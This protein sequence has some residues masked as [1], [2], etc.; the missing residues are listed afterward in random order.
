MST[1]KNKAIL[2]QFLEAWNPRE[3]GDWKVCTEDCIFHG[4]AEEMSVGRMQQVSNM[5]FSAFPDLRGTIEDLVAEG[6]RVVSREAWRGTHEGEFMGIAP[7]GKQMNMK[8]VSIVRILDGRIAEC[9]T[10]F[11]RLALME[12]L[13]AAQPMG[14]GGG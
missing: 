10:F 11:D 3:G 13:G 1:E 5:Y 2:R 7:T 14:G 8:G 6:D 12:Q 4:V 9:W